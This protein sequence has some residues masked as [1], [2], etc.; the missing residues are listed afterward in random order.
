M[1][2]SPRTSTN[3]VVTTL[4]EERH[5][6]KPLAPREYVPMTCQG[7][8]VGVVVASAMAG[9]A[10]TNNDAAATSAPAKHLVPRRRRRDNT[11]HV[12]VS[13]AVDPIA[14]PPVIVYAPSDVQHRYPDP[15]VT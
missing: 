11:E 8:Y 15:H 7:P 12:N 2:T 1:A 6:Q 4:A 13:Q 10:A 5:G 3:G 9:M 14:R